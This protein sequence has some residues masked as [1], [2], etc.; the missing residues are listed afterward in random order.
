MMIATHCPTAEQLQAFSLGR[1]SEHESDT[2]LDHIRDCKTC[3]SHLETVADDQ[4]SLVAALRSPDD[5][6]PYDAEPGCQTALAKALAALALAD[7]GEIGNEAAGNTEPP[8]PI[9]IG[10]YEIVRPLGRGGMGSVFLARHTKLGRE[11]AVKLLAGHRLADPRMRQRFEAEMRAIGRLSHPNIVAAHDARD[12]DGTAV[13]VTEYIDGLDLGQLVERRGP[14]A[15][16][17]ACEIVRQVA[18]ALA[19]TS[20]QGFVHRDIKPSNIM[21]SQR[22][23]VKLLDLGLARWQWDEVEQTGMT[24]TGQALGTADYVA[25]EQVTDSRRV[26]VRAD[27]Y[28]LGCTLFKLLCGTAPFAA[29]EHATAFAKMTAHVSTRPPS[30]AQHVPAAPAGL[31]KLVDAMLAKDP[32][33]RP[34]TPSAVAEQLAAYC[35]GA[36]LPRLAAAAAAAEKPSATSPEVVSRA[37]HRT[38]PLLRRPVPLLV[39]IAAGLFGVLLGFAMG[40]V[41]TITKPDGSKVTLAV[42]DGSDIDIRDVPAGGDTTGAVEQGAVGLPIKGQTPA[43][44]VEPLVFAILVEPSEVDAAARQAAEQQ[45]KESTSTGPVSTDIGTWYPVSGDWDA[46]I[47]M[48]HNDQRYT[49]ASHDRERMIGWEESRPYLSIG[50]GTGGDDQEVVLK[51]EFS[52]PLATRVQELTRSN[53]H[54]HLAVIVDGRVITAPKIM[55]ELGSSAHITGNFTAED[56][57]RIDRLRRTGFF[58]L[59]SAPKETVMQTDRL[60]RQ[61]DSSGQLVDGLGRP[62]DSSGRLLTQPPATTSATSDDARGSVARDAGTPE[63]NAQAAAQL[64][65]VWRL[66]R[67]TVGGNNMDKVAT[68]VMAFDGRKYYVC[69]PDFPVGGGTFSVSHKGQHPSIDFH[70]QMIR[71][72]SLPVMRAIY[73]INVDGRLEIHSDQ[74]P[75]AALPSNFDVSDPAPTLAASVLERIGDLPRSPEEARAL[76]GDQ[77]P[78]LAQALLTLVKALQTPPEKLAFPTLDQMAAVNMQKTSAANLKQIG[79]AFHNFHDMHGN[80]P[81]SSNES[82]GAGNVADGQKIYPFSWRVALLP[83]LREDELYKQYRFDEPWDS[84]HNQTLLSKMPRVYQSPYID[85]VEPQ[86]VGYT[87]YQGL[88]GPQTALGDSDGESF[89]TFT[90]GTSPTL[91]IVESQASVPWTQPQDLRFEKPE[92]AQRIKPFEDQPLNF[93]TADA[94]THSMDPVDYEKLAKLITRNGGE[95]VKP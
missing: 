1:L 29:A 50:S 34:Q 91:L 37:P 39:A 21:L 56:I 33:K 46:P 55:S 15:I 30:L 85:L 9:R 60:G 87:H 79:L 77:D 43:G 23:D 19:Y 71:N 62:I 76:A 27:I 5:S 64:Q 11:V 95:S 52:G 68:S 82:E 53:L 63:H 32:A 88:V 26:D 49:L 65:G 78:K 57:R 40:I 80:L 73:R 16:A 86:P 35:S 74:A 66:I 3:Q 25:P 6:A 14:L 58:D 89:H 70:D 84:E 72:E 38:Q 10:E 36:D 17:D 92:D 2:F 81:G 61:V 12:V 54:R 75:L 93:L 44:A 51:L 22:G 13:L 7:A 20:G 28:S 59:W 4:D 42:P 83:Y 67:V 8:L 69:D 41:I 94:A 47:T 18:V 24:A 48:T 45:L 31:V 90:D